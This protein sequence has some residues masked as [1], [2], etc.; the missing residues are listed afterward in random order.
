MSCGFSKG[1]K[2]VLNIEREGGDKGIPPTF[3]VEGDHSTSL[4]V[5]GRDRGK[6][7]LYEALVTYLMRKGS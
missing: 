1:S 6:G 3:G 2:I 5:D 4:A 7:K